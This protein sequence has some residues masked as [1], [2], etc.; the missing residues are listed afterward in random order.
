MAASNAELG[1]LTTVPGIGHPTGDYVH[2]W[3]ILCFDAFKHCF[4]AFKQAI[5]ELLNILK[6]NAGKN[7]AYNDSP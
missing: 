4:D 7:N 1:P 2:Q 3:S 5:L 6:N